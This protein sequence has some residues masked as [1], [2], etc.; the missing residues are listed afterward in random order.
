MRIS[1]L[2]LSAI[3]GVPAFTRSPSFT[4]SLG[5]RPLKSVG[6]T[7]IMLGEMFLAIWFSALPFRGMFKP[8]RHRILFDIFFLKICGKDTHYL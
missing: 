2:F 6:F 4:R 7:A 3:T 8:L 1:G 5:L